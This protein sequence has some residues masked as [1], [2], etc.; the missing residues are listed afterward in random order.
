MYA[1]SSNRIR[2]VESLEE[3]LPWWNPVFVLGCAGRATAKTQAPKI[4]RTVG[5]AQPNYNLCAHKSSP[6]HF[7]RMPEFLAVFHS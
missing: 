5:S 6:E 2:V 1:S 4:T 7:L 3:W